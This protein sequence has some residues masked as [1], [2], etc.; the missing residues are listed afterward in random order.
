MSSDTRVSFTSC[1]LSLNKSGLLFGDFTN[2]I[3]VILSGSSGGLA[4]CLLSGAFG[5]GLLF[6]DLLLLIDGLL[7]RLFLLEK[8]DVLRQVLIDSGHCS[9]L[10]RE[11]V[12]LAR[13]EAEQAV[14]VVID[15]L[16]LLHSSHKESVEFVC[17]LSFCFL[18]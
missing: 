14:K 16:S 12:R 4:C 8:S 10:L 2:L 3:I 15:T 17:R 9:F 5:C 18:K 6:G 11:E 7:L 13:K 1:F